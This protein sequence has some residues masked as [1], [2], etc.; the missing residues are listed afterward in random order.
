MKLHARK[1]TSVYLPELLT[2]GRA[3][4][5]LS[6]YYKQ[7]LKWTRGSFELLFRVYPKLFRQF[8]WMQRIHYFL[9]PLYFFYGIIGL[10]DLFIPLY[11]LGTY[12]VP[13]FISFEAFLWRILP[14]I[15]GVFVVRHYA[16]RFLLDENEKGFHFFGGLLRVGTWWI[17]LKGFLYAILGKK[18]PYLPTPKEGVIKN[19]W[20]ISI[21]N[22]LVILLSIGVLMVGLERDWNPYSFIM[23][24]FSVL[25]IF[26]LSV[27]TLLGL[28]KTLHGFLES[29]RGGRLR[30]INAVWYTFKQKVV[31]S[32]LS[33]NLVAALF[34]LITLGIFLQNTMGVVPGFI[35]PLKSQSTG[36]HL[37][38]DTTSLDIEKIDSSAL[39]T[40]FREA[41]C[42]Y[43]TAKLNDLQARGIFFDT[44]TRQFDWRVSGQPLYIKGVQYNPEEGWRDGRHPLTRRQLEHDFGLIK[45]MGANTISRNIPTVYDRNILAIA[46]ETGLHVIYGFDFNPSI[47]YL[48]EKEKVEDLKQNILSKVRRFRRAPSLLAWKLGNGT[49][50][51]LA[52]HFS[53]PR[54]SEVRSAFLTELNDISLAIKQIDSRHPVLT[55][56]NGKEEL[57]WG[58]KDFMSLA[59]AID[60]IIVNAY[61]MPVIR[62]L[63]KV[64]RAHQLP[65]LVLSFYGGLEGLAWDDKGRLMEPSAYEKARSYGR[66]WTQF[67]EGNRSVFLG[68]LAYCWMDRYQHSV[69]LHGITDFRGRL[70]PAYYALK[71]VWTGVEQRFPL[72][73]LDVRTYWWNG[74]AYCW[75]TYQASYDKTHSLEWRIVEDANML[76]VATIKSR[77]VEPGPVGSYFLD[78]YF[79]YHNKFLEWFHK[80]GY[81]GLVSPYGINYVPDEGSGEQRFYLYLS[82]HQGNVVTASVAV[83]LH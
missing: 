71:E 58:M 20:T 29:L 30:P 69:S 41:P 61:E 23:A 82:D 40:V 63:I 37:I 81:V 52:Q 11:S 76:P 36:N 80:R 39:E 51:A 50:E 22:I 21:P 7:Q 77:P 43:T 75:S 79:K 17:Y 83:P 27:V 55:T 64:A 66:I 57:W 24:G 26:L 45:E 67:I 33:N 28:Q 78:R 62:Q 13:L 5:S 6:A 72:G 10:I 60:L 42:R 16:Q 38:A 74:R 53:E 47:D 31:Y 14:V 73:D 46:E 8:S 68:G 25:N 70:K 18:V 3:P 65:P 2:R 49:W 1:W 32:L 19:E 15:V 56:F 59:P 54:L 4:S 34:L 44:L 35:K 48:N 12:Q 9:T